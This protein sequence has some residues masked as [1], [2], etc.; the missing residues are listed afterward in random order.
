MRY[1]C[2]LKALGLLGNELSHRTKTFALLMTPHEHC[3]PPNHDP[4]QDPRPT[5]QP[6]GGLSNRLCLEVAG[7]I[8]TA[9]YPRST[10]YISSYLPPRIHQSSLSRIPL[11]SLSPSECLPSPPP[12]PD[13]ALPSPA[14]PSLSAISIPASHFASRPSWTKKYLLGGPSGLLTRTSLNPALSYSCSPVLCLRKT[15]WCVGL[16]RDI[17]HCPVQCRTMASLRQ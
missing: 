2:L 3:S 14:L 4:C 11:P 7:S 9:K 5:T 17:Q 10:S 8:P 6:Q 16:H 12:P 1:I 13:A 15:M